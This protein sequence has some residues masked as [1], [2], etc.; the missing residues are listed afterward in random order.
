MKGDTADGALS[1]MLQLALG[2]ARQ[3]QAHQQ[4][5]AE[6]DRHLAHLRQDLVP[7][8][9]G[10]GTCRSLKCWASSTAALSKRRWRASAAVQTWHRL[11]SKHMPA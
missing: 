4:A 3:A 8:K 1:A 9:V 5:L 11:F 10:P 7:V 6:V 2:A